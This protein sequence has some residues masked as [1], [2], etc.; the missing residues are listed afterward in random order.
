MKTPKQIKKIEIELEDESD[1]LVEGK[2][3]RPEESAEPD[4]D[5]EKPRKMAK[6]GMV[7]RKSIQLAGWG[8]A[9]RR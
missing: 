2:E 1:D 6:G 9:R 7:K 5:E 8:K 4:E 3:M